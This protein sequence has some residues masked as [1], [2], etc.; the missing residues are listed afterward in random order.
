M[1]R[2]SSG[3]LAAFASVTTLFFAWGF[4]TSNNDPLI[5]ALRAVFRLSYAEAL[6]TQF[7]FF[8]AYG[9]ASIPAAAL[10]NKLGSV[11][12]ILAALGT[13]AFACLVIQLTG[14][15]DSYAVVLVALFIL[16]VGIT[17]LQ[18]AANPLA[19][20][21]GAPERSHFRLTFAQAFNSLG[22]VLGVH[23]GSQ[24]MLDKSV[25]GAGEFTDA[26][27]RAAALGAVEHAFVLI[28]IFL[29][30]LALFIWVQRG[31]IERATVHLAPV[32]SGGV[33]EALRAP[34]ALFGAVAIFLYVGA[35]VSI[36]S[37]M[38]NFLNRPNI[39]N[40]SLEAAG[41][42]LANYYWGGALVGRF[43]GSALLTRVPAARLLTGAATIAALLCLT[44]ALTD[45]P[46]AAYAALAVGFFNSIM[47]PTIFTLTLE[48]SGVSEASTSGL[49]C[50]AIVGGAFL[51]LLTGAIADAGSLMAAFVV[52]LVAYVVIAFFAFRALGARL[53]HMPDEENEFVS[54]H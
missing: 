14:V 3:V 18:V 50:L 17:A 45:G 48:R 16:A 1:Q 10:L 26:A 54:P 42:M 5:A 34:W 49:L 30:L 44:V 22:V 28:A 38:I 15:L 9:I 23:F 39:L 4:I 21:L 11:R 8:L 47:F 29:V 53:T 51:P 27:S 24:I 12:T 13:M 40:V 33:M 6:V 41:V 46:T 31:R 43:V 37:I 32:T 7:A 25:L 36:G 2:Q 19:A 20:A 52:P 35:E